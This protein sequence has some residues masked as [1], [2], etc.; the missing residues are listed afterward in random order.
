MEVSKKEDASNRRKQ[1]VIYVVFALF[2]LLGFAVI[3]RSREA[4]REDTCRGLIEDR[5]LLA[6]ALEDFIPPEA[7]QARPQLQ[8]S[9]QKIAL[10]LAKPLAIC[11]RVGIDSVVVLNISGVVVPP[12]TTS[13][14]VTTQAAATPPSVV[15]VIPQGGSAQDGASGSSGQDGRQGPAGPPGQ[16]GPP[17]SSPPT[18]QPPQQ[19]PQQQPDLCKPLPFAPRIC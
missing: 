8:A 19:P 3:G 9:L 14:S 2:I 13:S 6:G 11:E 5:H 12:T 17:G 1:I 10:R 15:V 18:T 4:S 7:V 16:Q